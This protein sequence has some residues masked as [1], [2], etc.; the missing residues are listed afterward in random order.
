MTDAAPPAFV[1]VHQ[2]LDSYSHPR[3]RPWFPEH[4]DVPV[5]AE[6]SRGTSSPWPSGWEDLDS[7]GSTRLPPRPDP[8]FAELGVIRMRGDR[9]L[10]VQRFLDDCYKTA[11]EIRVSLRGQSVWMYPV[12]ALPHQ[13]SDI[14]PN[15]RTG[16]I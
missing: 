6:P 4:V 13:R 2:R 16:E 8:T 9:L 5:S 14:R 1:R 12:V 11:G 7:P 3:E 15:R 10:D